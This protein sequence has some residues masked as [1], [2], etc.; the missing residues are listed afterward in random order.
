[1]NTAL[2]RKPYEYVQH[3]Q[4]CELNKFKTEA[5]PNLFKPNMTWLTLIT[6]YTLSRQI[7]VLCLG[8]LIC[9]INY[10]LFVKYTLSN[11]TH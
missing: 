3:L 10:C 6:Q 8:L 11:Y 1:M 2:K 5:G 4:V 9:Y 7:D